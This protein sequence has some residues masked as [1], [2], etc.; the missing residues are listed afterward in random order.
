M[1]VKMMKKAKHLKF[2]GTFLLFAVFGFVLLYLYKKFF[3][4]KQENKENQQNKNDN[5]NEETE[6]YIVNEKE[7]ISISNTNT[8]KNRS[9]I[10]PNRL[11][12]EV[13]KSE[14]N[15]P[16]ALIKQMKE[17]KKQKVL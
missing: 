3:S 2:K 10:I 8:H 13:E 9:K 6:K 17:L 7:N 11:K 5:I 16:K 4:K 15:A 12:K 14:Y 1:A